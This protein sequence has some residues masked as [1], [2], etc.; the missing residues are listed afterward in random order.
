M[1]NCTYNIIF[2]VLIFNFCLG[3]KVPEQEHKEEEYTKEEGSQENQ[4]NKDNKEEED[5]SYQPTFE[6]LYCG[7]MN[8]YD[9][10]GVTRFSN[11]QSQ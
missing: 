7:S 2:L 3:H 11:F 4:E 5:Y 10:L 9:L 8:C 1:R 6:D